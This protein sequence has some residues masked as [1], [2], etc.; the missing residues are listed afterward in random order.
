MEGAIFL[1]GG[2]DLRQ[3]DAL[4]TEF[5]TTVSER[6]DN[7]SCLYIPHA[8]ETGRHE[9]ALEWFKGGY[10]R[11]FS[12][13]VVPDKLADESLQERNFDAIYIGGGNTGHLLDQVRQSNFASYMRQHL[14]RGGIVYGGSAGATILGKTILTALSHE[15]S[16]HDND[17]LDLL[18]GM[19]VMPHYSEENRSRG[20][21]L[22]RQ[23]GVKIIAIPEVAGVI[24]D[25]SGVRSVG[26]QPVLIFNPNGTVHELNELEPFTT[27]N[28]RT[29]QAYVDNIDKFVEL[30]P[31]DMIGDTKTWIDR[32]LS[33]IDADA[34]ILELGSGFGR[35][36]HYMRERGFTVACSDA[37]LGF[38][39]ILS[40]AGFDARPLD[41]VK[42]EF[43][44]GHDLVYA[45][46]IFEHLTRNQL[47]A[48]F[49][50]V[51]RSL[52]ES[53][54]FAFSVRQG[55]G[56]VWSDEKL[57]APRYF[58]LWEASN[59]SKLLTANGFSVDSLIESV[60]YQG[61]KRLYVI[62]QKPQA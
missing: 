4:D 34:D 23:L 61:I 24:L 59:M 30:T 40:E 17:G 22:A 43:G 50:K 47:D 37:V 35:D 45:N 49:K 46:A 39:K 57:E 12:G 29:L 3:S 11:L 5:A 9:K 32:T 7:P 38:V 58:C 19:S 42:D 55:T 53:G 13:I 54:Y 14:E 51:H 33:L 18:G 36:A 52:N 41:V 16:A 20:L 27:E 56:E 2:G 48:V 44:N 28:E 31:K 21:D 8:M 26:E 6:N 1:G 10:G 15:H 25:Q 62:G 60:G